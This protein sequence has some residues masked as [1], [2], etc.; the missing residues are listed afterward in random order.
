MRSNKNPQR[1]AFVN[2]VQGGF[3]VYS[4]HQ[5]LLTFAATVGVEGTKTTLLSSTARRNLYGQLLAKADHLSTSEADRLLRAMLELLHRGLAIHEVVAL[6]RRDI[7]I[8][9]RCVR[10]HGASNKERRVK[11]SKGTAD[12]LNEY[13][14]PGGEDSPYLV[15][16]K[17]LA[18][19]RSEIWKVVKRYAKVASLKNVSPHTLRHSFAT[20]L[21]QGGADSRSVQALLGHSDISTTQ[22]YLHITTD[23]LRAVYNLHHPRG[24][25]HD[26]E[27]ADNRRRAAR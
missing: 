6:R 17:E 21:L 18:M 27:S 22:I 3:T 25:D 13:A 26:G 16:S 24:G 8:R 20:H 2:L 9:S 7:D 23:R 11:I 15:H 12:R 1:L 5:R 14:G 10:V 4:A 19:S